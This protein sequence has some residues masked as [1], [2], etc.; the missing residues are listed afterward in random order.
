MGFALGNDE[1]VCE[2]VAGDAK[3]RAWLADVEK[4][5]WPAYVKLLPPDR[6]QTPVKVIQRRIPDKATGSRLYWSLTQIAMQFNRTSK[7]YPS[8]YEAGAPGEEPTLKPERERITLVKKWMA[9]GMSHSWSDVLQRYL[10]H[11]SHVMVPI[12]WSRSQ[13]ERPGGGGEAEVLPAP[14]VVVEDPAVSGPPGADAV[15]SP[16]S[17]S[18]SSSSSPSWPLD[19]FQMR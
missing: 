1:F 6:V 16:S 7:A 8:H 15:G 11:G 12:H 4:E 9:S 2:R 19:F 13:K 10:A 17:S 3:K 5:T 14:Q 18:S